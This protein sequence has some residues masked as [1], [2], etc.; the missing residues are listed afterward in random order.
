M[1]LHGKDRPLPMPHPFICTIIRVEEPRL[2]FLR[3]CFLVYSEAMVLRCNVAT[4]GS[5]LN[6]GL[7]LAAMAILQLERIGANGKGQELM[8]QTDSK[9]GDISS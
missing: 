6:A 4:L 3:Q 7:V 1:E 8:S 2:P 5:Y 9:N